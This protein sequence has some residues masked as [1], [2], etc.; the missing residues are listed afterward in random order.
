M[1]ERQRPSNEDP[2]EGSRRTVER[3]LNRQSGGGESGKAKGE[4]GDPGS[5][6]RTSEQK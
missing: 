4:S 2:A 3:E 5:A 6:G 1:A